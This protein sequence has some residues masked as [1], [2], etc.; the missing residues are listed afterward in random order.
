VFNGVVVANLQPGKVFEWR[1][2]VHSVNAVILQIESWQWW[3]TW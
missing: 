1:Q 2:S 3:S